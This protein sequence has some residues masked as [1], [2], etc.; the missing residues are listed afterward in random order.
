MRLKS[1]HCLMFLVMAV[2][3]VYYPTLHAGFNSTDDLNMVSWIEQMG[4]I[5]LNQLF[6]PQGTSY[7]Y[8]PLTILSYLFDRE[9]WGTIPSFMHLEN[10]LLHLACALLVFAITLRL[11]PL[12]K[13]AKQWPALFA[14]L[15]FALHPLAT[16]SV[17]WV[18]GRTD[19]LMT[20]F[21]LLAV[22][23]ILIALEL[24]SFPAALGAGVALCLAGLAKEIAVFILPGVVW[25]VVVYPDEG[26]W[27]ERIRRR[28]WTLLM[29]TAGVVGYFI[30]RHLATA[31][32]SGVSTAL[33]GVVDGDYDLLNKVRIAFKVYGF[34]FKKLLIPWPL[35]FGIVEVSGWY[36]LSGI[37]LAA[38]LLYLVRRADVPGAFGLMAFFT[39]SPAL[40]VVF[41]HMAWTPLAERY[42]YTSVALFAPLAAYLVQRLRAFIN[43]STRRKFDLVLVVL[44]LVFF[45]T[46]LHRAWIWQDNLRLYRDTVAKSPDLE[47]A[48]T[49]LAAALL[50]HGKQAEAEEILVGMQ[51]GEGAPEYINDDINLAQI[52]S[53]KGDFAGARAVLLS[54]LNAN[55]KKYYLVLQSLLRVNDQRLSKITDPAGRRV[56]Q[57]ESLAWLQEQQRVRPNAFTLYRLAKQ[58]LSMG[59]KVLALDF[60]RKAYAQSPVDA[61]YRGA[62]ETFIARIEKQG[63]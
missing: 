49:E 2:L 48:K 36:V 40:L 62:A 37:V 35:N 39:L 57:K 60:F 30:L 4:P 18:S 10:I 32:D 7:Y 9:A 56:L 50:R 34:Y 22:W 44:L 59:Q 28:C 46:T 17:C 20:L 6:F 33:K 58:H 14:G 31:Y 54:Q 23:L 29:P 8:R 61:H 43:I 11:L 12:W 16:E 5:D 25:L 52:L 19:P 63:S 53:S 3:V 55:P 15:F 24:D 45:G 47:A 27:L 26:G 42:L 1:W 38:L 51:G 13:G 21:I 41:G